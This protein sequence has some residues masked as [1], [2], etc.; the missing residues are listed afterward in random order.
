VPCYRIQARVRSAAGVLSPVQTLSAP[1]QPAVS[2]QVAVDPNGNA[3]FVWERY[4][5]TTNCQGDPCLRI[6]AVARSATGALSA[7]QTLSAVGSHAVGPDVGV[8]Q[9]GNAVFGWRNS[10][11]GFVQARARSATGALSPIQVIASANSYT[12]P[13]LAVDADG[14]AVFIWSTPTDLACDPDGV[15]QCL[16]TRTRVRTATGSLTPVQGLSAYAAGRDGSDGDVAV[17]P[18]GNAVFD[19]VLTD[20]NAGAQRIQGRARAADGT[21]SGAPLLSAPGQAA[22]DPELGVDQSANAVFV[23]RRPDGTTDCGGS[24]CDRI[25]ARARSADGTLS[26]TQTISAAGGRAFL[27]DIAVDPNGNAVVVWT[28]NDGTTGCP[29][30]PTIQ[31]GCVRVQ[32]RSRSAAGTL[33]SVQ[34]LSAAGQD[35]ANGG[36]VG[37][38]QSGHAVA[39]WSRFGG[40]NWRIQAAAG[41]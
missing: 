27:P 31:P 7:V 8:D 30:N 12:S 17:D 37:I 39:V 33:G 26:S 41:P 32:A 35:A 24:S 2:P 1:G 21:L 5:G 34:T 14:D 11:V 28:R 13:D 16:Q 4:D 20:W 25:E 18:N 40:T 9:N 15:F 6:Q 38:D 22:I 10:T 36:K 23:W 29:P 19:W 3:V